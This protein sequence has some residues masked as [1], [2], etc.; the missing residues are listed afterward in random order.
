MRARAPLD[1][2]L[3]DK[4]LYGLTPMRL[5]YLVV[6]LLGGFALWSSPWAPSPA[7]AFA[8]FAVVATGAVAAWGRWRGRA[9]DG[10][11][12]D[13]SIFIINTHRVVWNARWLRRFQPR[14]TRSIS[15]HPPTS[16][17]AIVVSGRTPKA[18]ATTVAVELAACL[19]I[20]GYSEELWSVRRAA[21]SH[22]RKPSSSAPLVS[23]VSVDGGRV[24]Y[25][26]SGAGPRVA[27]VIPEDEHVRQAAALNQPTVVAFPDAPVSKAFIDLL[28]VIAAA[29]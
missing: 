11:V 12:A 2:D 28:D 24:C 15:K 25:L 21:A 18:G 14:R 16:P 19:A 9:V 17:I 27:G 4:L 3:E 5:A 1:V 23:V 6:A 13:I 7:R 8:C 10:W 22:D 20:R 26:D 29:G